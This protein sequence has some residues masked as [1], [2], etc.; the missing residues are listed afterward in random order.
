[1]FDESEVISHICKGD[2]KA[3]DLLVKQH[4]NLVFHMVAQVSNIQEEIED[5]SQE[6]FIKIFHHLKNFHFESKLSTW[7]ARIAYRTALDHAWKQ[8][9]RRGDK[10]LTELENI[11][12]G[13][14][15]PEE[16]LDRKYVSETLQR[17]I[18]QL[19]NQYRLVLNLYHFNEFSYEE[20]VQITG[21]P[22]G[23]VKTHLFRARKMLKDKLE[24]S[25]FRYDT[26]E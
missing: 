23:T 9:K 20:I 26:A 17:F 18:A 12:S 22:E 1:M 19:P 10:G 24:T 15:G 8:K 3:F 11:G 6:V 7:I 16:I 13:S 4:E 21:L 14:S 2:L 5:I 25:N